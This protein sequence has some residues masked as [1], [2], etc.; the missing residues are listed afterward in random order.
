MSEGHEVGPNW[1]DPGK[2]DSDSGQLISSLQQ[3]L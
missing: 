2:L 1:Q 3:A